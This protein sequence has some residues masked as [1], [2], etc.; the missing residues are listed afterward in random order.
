MNRLNIAAI[1]AAAAV[2]WSCQSAP[3]A[4]DNQP[5]PLPRYPVFLVHGIGFRSHS[6]GNGT[7][8]W[9][10]VT[11]TLDKLGVPWF[12]SDQ[13]AFGL[14]EENA[15]TLKRDILAWL[16]IHPG[17]DKVNIIAHSRGGL[18][19]RYLVSR[20]DMADKV[21]SITMLST[22]NR[23]STLTNKVYAFI[24]SERSLAAWGTDA[25]ATL[26]G[27][28]N[29]QSYRAGRQL[30]PESMDEFN[31]AVPDASGVFYQ[32][33]AGRISKSYPNPFLA[34]SCQ[35][36]EKAEGENDGMV[37]VESA[38]W[39][40]FRGFPMGEDRPIISHHRIAGQNDF[41][42]TPLFDVAPFVAS[43]VADLA[44]RGY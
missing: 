27:D 21:A 39:G 28:V 10:G 20:L 26:Q 18:E 36:I 2:L 9:G 19:A 11:P 8:Y 31:Q 32:S 3:T 44:S 37:S 6:A 12:A 13:Q 25:F 24:G 35:I 15:E 42:Q 16:A 4:R 7:E 40:L 29:P 17:Y 5:P 38:K 34:I 23:G 30:L 33:Y 1:V 43:L 22:P 41:D 14:I